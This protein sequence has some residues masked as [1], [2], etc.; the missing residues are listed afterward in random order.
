MAIGDVGGSVNTVTL[1]CKSQAACDGQ[2]LLL[3]DIAR[4]DAVRLTGGYEVSNALT[5]GCRVVGVAQARCDAPGAALPVQMGGV[6]I[7]DYCGAEPMI[8]GGICGSDQAGRVRGATW[9]DQ[10]RVGVVLKVTASDKL[11][12]VLM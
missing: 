7:F 2:K 5:N 8:G 10:A 9:A 3:C 1:T 11:V 12:H 4:H 6:I